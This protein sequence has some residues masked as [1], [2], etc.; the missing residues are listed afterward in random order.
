M[1]LKQLAAEHPYY[2]STSNYH[3]N[4][5]NKEWETATDFLN[6]YENA[7]IDMNLIFRFDVRQDD[8]SGLYN[9]EVFV[10]HQRQGLFAPHYIKSITEDEAERF[11]QLLTNHWNVLHKVW[12][13]IAPQTVPC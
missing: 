9:A 8:E 10:I 5:A 4:T 7:D 11:A 6:D 1:T 12:A 13:P 3:S 2:C